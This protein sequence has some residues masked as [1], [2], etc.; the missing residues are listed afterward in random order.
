M[1]SRETA[2]EGP[3][4]RPRRDEKVEMSRTLVWA[5]DLCLGSAAAHGFP[6]PSVC[7]G[8]RI[9]VV[10]NGGFGLQDLLSDAS[11]KGSVVFSTSMKSQCFS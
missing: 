1:G 7:G 2:G 9:R 3:E 8:G 4:M 6:N 5:C 11:G 10:L